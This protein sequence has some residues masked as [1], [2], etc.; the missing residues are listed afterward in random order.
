MLLSR[1]GP[2]LEKELS[3]VV[4][5]RYGTVGAI[6]NGERCERYVRPPSGDKFQTIARIAVGLVQCLAGGESPAISNIDYGA[7]KQLE[8]DGIKTRF[9]QHLFE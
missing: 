1:G 2:D 8:D 5:D 3:F 6:I 7:I 9:N 4:P